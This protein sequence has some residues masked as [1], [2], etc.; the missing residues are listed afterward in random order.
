MSN[1]KNEFFALDIK[2]GII[3]WKQQI[4]SEIRPVV[5]SN[6]IVTISNEGLFVIINKN[7]GNI[8]RINN[9]LKNI[10]KKKEKNIIQLVLSLVTTK[11]ILQL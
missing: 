6:Y 10:K 9:I 4:N 2:T 7:D 3:K 8:L 1:N 5:V 11:F